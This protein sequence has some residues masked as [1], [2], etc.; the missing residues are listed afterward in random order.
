MIHYAIDKIDDRDYDAETLLWAVE[1]LPKQV[2]LKDDEIQNQRIK[3]PM[4]CVFY[5]WSSISNTMNYI[6]WESQRISWHDLSAI[7]IERKLLNPK[8]WAFISSSPKLLKD[9]WY[10]TAY[11][12]C[13]S[14]NQI[15]LALFHKK[16]VQTWSRRID[17]KET[18]A[19]NNIAIEWSVYWH[20]FFIC[21]YDDN[22]KLLICENSYWEESYTNWY[23]FI[24]YEDINLLFNWKYV[25]TDKVD[26]D[27]LYK[28]QIMENIN[29]EKAK[30]AMTNW[31]WSWINP[32][33]TASREEVATMNQ[34]VYEKLLKKID[35]IK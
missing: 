18:R 16:P 21:W 3:D 28:K 34:R 2:F 5:T 9:L 4:G 23:F 15:R 17:W 20:S 25:M 7:A 13:N 27:L 30:E 35:W 31:F 29:I 22:K 12:N 32:T 6:A 1:N 24:K 26:A 33:W 8:K 10:I 19:N 14:L 11:A